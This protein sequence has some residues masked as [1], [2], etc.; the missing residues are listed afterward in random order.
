VI[1]LKIL[2]LTTVVGLGFVGTS[3]ANPL[4]SPGTVYIDGLPCNLPCQ[5]Y[6][7]WSRQTLK[8]GQ[9]SSKKAAKTSVAEEK[10]APETRISK[11][12]EPISADRPHQ[13][14]ARGLQATLKPTPNSPDVSTS[15]TDT[16]SGVKTRN[17]PAPLVTT[18]EPQ[19]GSRSETGNAP[20]SVNAS[21]PPEQKKSLQQVV[22]A[23]LSVAEQITNTELPKALGNDHTDK[24]KVDETN[25]PASGLLVALVLSRPELRSASALNDQDVAID[26]AE[27]T[28]EPE[29]RSALAAMGAKE[30][31]VSVSDTSPLDRLINGDV[32]AALVKLVSPDAA[33]AFPDIKGYK[34]LRV[35][36]FA[37]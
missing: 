19:P 15:R 29:I 3:L 32:Q 37:R 22:L 17:S 27:S 13:K 5:H 31:R 10:K 26:R 9:P 7:E 4:D 25:V 12:A 8:A 16:S 18:A 1:S 6:L 28:I 20:L 21:N 30:A 23:A 36:L 24:T 11:Q 33:E 34:V 2:A 14:K 35:P